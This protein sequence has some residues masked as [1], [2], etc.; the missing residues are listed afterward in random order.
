MSSVGTIVC[1]YLSHLEEP[2]WRKGLILEASDTKV[3]MVVRL[4]REEPSQ[5][6]LG[7]CF[8]ISEKHYMLVTAKETNSGPRLLLLR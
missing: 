2:R 1:A 5:E 8:E 4:K 7:T 3:I 6:G